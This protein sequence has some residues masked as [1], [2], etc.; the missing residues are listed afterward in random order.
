MTFGSFI[1]YSAAF[2]LLIRVVFG[3]LPDG[4][5]NPNAPYHVNTS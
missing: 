5:I 2:P 4:A 3:E 1:G